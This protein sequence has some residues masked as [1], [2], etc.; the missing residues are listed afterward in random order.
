MDRYAEIKAR[1]LSLAQADDTLQAVI[2]IGSST[3]SDVPADEFSDLDLIIATTR[4]EDW[5]YGDMPDRL[6]DVRISF[7]EPTLGGG[8]ERRMLYAGSR[9]V[10]LIVFTPEQ[11]TQA[12]LDG[13]AGWVMNRGYDVMHDAMGITPLIAQ[14]VIPAAGFTPM[15][16]AEFANVVNDFFF[17]AVWA[18]KKLRRGE[19]WTAKMCIDAYLKRLL[20]RV[21]ELA[22]CVSADVWHDGRF[23]DRWAGNEA[24][25][26]L[27]RIWR[28]PCVQRCAS[29]CGAAGRQPAPTGMHGR[30]PRRN[31]LNRCWGLII[32]PPMAYNTT[33]MRNST[34]TGDDII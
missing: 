18:D 21:L 3:R 11:L 15:G 1:L 20:L 26:A 33:G 5:L 29:L 6:G 16:E 25:E 24:V 14:H 27:R 9:D 10:D 31:A 12:V 13:V 28:G 7:T 32:P 23:L 4:P 34:G 17:H 8:M 30:P 22:R 2:A 19:T